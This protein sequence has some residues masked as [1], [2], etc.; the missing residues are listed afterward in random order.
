MSSRDVVVIGAS[1]GGVEALTKIVAALP[2]DFAAAV[3][4]VLHL[5]EDARSQLPAIL[6]RTG[7]LPAAHAVD[8]EPIRRSRIY[9]AP[10]GFQTAVHGG[11][12]SVKRGPRENLHRPSVDVLFRTAAHYFGARATGVVLSGALDDGEAGL[13]AVKKVG[14]WRSCRTRVMRGSLPCRRARQSTSIP[15]MSCRPTRLGR[16]SAPSW[17]PGLARCPAKLCS[18]PCCSRRS[19]RRRRPRTRPVPISLVPD[20]VQLSGLRRNAVRNQG[21]DVGEVPLSRRTR[22]F[23]GQRGAGAR[24]LGRT[25]PL[26]LR[27]LEERAALMD[28]LASFARHRGGAALA[29]MFEE[30][31]RDVNDDVRAVHELIASGR[32]LETIQEDDVAIRE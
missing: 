30:R 15:T 11:R 31:S 32:T 1:S 28:K 19:R 21:W 9:V 13:L 6:N 4:V 29:T 10:P 8:G 2:A 5:G 18:G 7:P 25:R 20:N 14:E 23:R 26:A 16:F 24:G 12:L 17:P 27:A 3:F 22:V